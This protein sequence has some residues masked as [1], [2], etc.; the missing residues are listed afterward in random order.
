M[1]IALVGGDGRAERL[2]AL[3]RREGERVHS[4]ALEKAA[5]PA[6]VPR[7]NCLSACVYGAELILLPTPAERGG[8]LN[9]PLSEKAL[10]MEE[11]W[12]ALWP[13]QLV[14]GGGF[15]EE[16]AATAL[17]GK[18]ELH[19]LLR[20]PG[21]V[22]ENAALTAEAAVGLLLHES[23]RALRQSR[24]LVLGFGR[25]GKLLALRL[26]GLGARV[27]VAAR[28]QAERALAAAVGCETLGLEELEGR[29]GDF[30]FIVNTIPS[31]VFG[32]AALCCVSPDALLLELASPPGGFDRELAGN[33]GL[34][35]LHAPGLPGRAFP[36]SAAALIKRETDAIIKEAHNG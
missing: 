25:V 1:K 9:A 13:G 7:E 12:A 21:F 28:R 22:T 20:R 33:I 27:C 32:D 24:C 36:L 8:L 15:S 34:R 16:S 35:V 6:E 23:E 3:L 19:D 30:D 29:A 31:R 4:F 10:P 11:L 5:L 18:Q 14:V 26:L 17:R 2:A